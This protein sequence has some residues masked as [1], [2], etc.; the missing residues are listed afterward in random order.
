M[1]VKVVNSAAE[2][3]EATVQL[4][5][6]GKLSDKADVTVLAASKACR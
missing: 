4:K 5:G 2:P 1:I 6:A 3:V